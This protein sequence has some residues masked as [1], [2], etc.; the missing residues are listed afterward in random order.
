MNDKMSESTIVFC[1][2]CNFYNEKTWRQIKN[3]WPQC[4]KCKKPMIVKL[5]ETDTA[6]ST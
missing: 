3:K 6:T 1:S 4:E 2:E 5:N